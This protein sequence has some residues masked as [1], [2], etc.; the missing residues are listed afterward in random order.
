M[1]KFNHFAVKANK[2]AKRCLDAL[3]VAE[4]EL[5][6]AEGKAKAH[7]VRTA[8]HIEADEQLI[9]LTAQADVLKAQEKLKSTRTAMCDTSRKLQAIRQELVAALTKP[10]K[11]IPA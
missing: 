1:T 8:G 10:G 7:S 5:R 3:A 11:Q 9:A 4:T 6:N 2:I